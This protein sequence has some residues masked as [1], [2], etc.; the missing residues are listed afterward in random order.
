MQRVNGAEDENSL[1]S[2]FREWRGRQTLA[3]PSSVAGEAHLR[4][5]RVPPDKRVLRT[6]RRLASGHPSILKRE[7]GDGLEH[8]ERPGVRFPVV[9]EEGPRADRACGGSAARIFCPGARTAAGAARVRTAAGGRRV[10][11]EVGP[12]ANNNQWGT[13]KTRSNLSTQ[14]NERRSTTSSGVAYLI[15]NLAQRS[16][17]VDVVLHDDN[18]EP[19]GGVF[20][21]FRMP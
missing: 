10:R 3:Q 7:P 5:V 9:L 2:F 13:W 15:A 21:I 14:T 17:R 18:V 20:P 8:L 16:R 12:A 1:H 19:L 6:L 11:R 4:R